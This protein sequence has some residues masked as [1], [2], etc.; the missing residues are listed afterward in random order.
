MKVKLT[1]NDNDSLL[2]EEI[3]K[4]AH[5]NYGEKVHVEVEPESNTPMDYLYF[6]IQRLITGDQLT[7]L[8]DSGANYHKDLEM[9]RVETVYKLEE[10]LREVFMDNEHRISQ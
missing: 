5:H 6:A 10:V 9:L 8:Y 3:I 7:L 4:T 1:Y 2:V